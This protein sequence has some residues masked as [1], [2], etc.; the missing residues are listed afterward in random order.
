[1]NIKD[2]IQTLFIK[3]NLWLRL[4]IL[5]VVCVLMLASFQFGKIV[6]YKQAGFTNRLGDNYRKAFDGQGRRFNK[7][8][9]PPLERGLPSSHGAVGKV[10]KLNNNSIIISTPENV[11]KVVVFSEN[12]LVKK[13]RETV[14]IGD[15]QNGDM[16]VVLGEPNDSGEIV[17]NLIRIMPAL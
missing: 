16:V 2:K 11:E 10:V 15:L 4:M 6:G 1:M 5:L 8:D 13:F 9:L 7:F 12:T 14:K 17:A 3:P